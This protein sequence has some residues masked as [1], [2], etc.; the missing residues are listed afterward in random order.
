MK[1]IVT[2]IGA[3]PQFIKAAALSKYLIGRVDIKE[4]LINTGQHYDSNMSDVFFEELSIPS[5]KHKLKS[6]G[7]THAEMTASQMINVEQILF[8]EKPDGVLVYGDTNSTLAGALVSA[9]LQIPLL[10][11]EAGLRSYNR[12]MPEEINRIVTDHLS[13]LLLC[14]SSEAVSN[15]NKEGISGNKVVITGDIM[16]DSVKAFLPIADSKSDFLK[17]YRLSPKSFGL[18]TIHR[19]DSTDNLVTLRNVV[20]GLIKA[21]R[22]LPL[23]WPVHPRTKKMLSLLNIDNFESVSLI[24]PI[25]YLD[26]LTAQQNASVIITDSGGVQKEAYFLRVPCITMRT[27]TEWTETVTSG[28]NKLISPL[29]NNSELSECIL[30][31]INSQGEEVQLYGDGFAAQR[32][33]ES[34]LK[35]L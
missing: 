34:A 15:L 25:G 31:S 18:I 17:T 3:R 2:I 22:E 32:I 20:T 21:S 19:A 11:V 6:G 30:N 12:N 7:K 10:H 26:M 33:V 14:T 35:V 4:V 1:K 9:K 24:D 29:G 27:E 5:P 8:D 23:V 28:W 16:L 13:S